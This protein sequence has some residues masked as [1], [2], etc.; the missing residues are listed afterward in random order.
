MEVS[1]QLTLKFTAAFF[2]KLCSF[3]LHA[4]DIRAHPLLFALKAALQAMVRI[5]E[6]Y[7]LVNIIY[8]PT[9]TKLNGIPDIVVNHQPTLD[10]LTVPAL[11]KAIRA[12]VHTLFGDY[13]SG[14]ID[15][16]LHGRFWALASAY[17]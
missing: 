1:Q 16:H 15:N 10:N 13:G 8:P 11:T 12:H 4:S 9:A 17:A 2:F 7:L 6:R 14:G 5:K 3:N